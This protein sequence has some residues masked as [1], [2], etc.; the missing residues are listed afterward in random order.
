MTFDGLKINQN[1]VTYSRKNIISSNIQFKK[2]QEL[3]ILQL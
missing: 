1:Y 2:G 3:C